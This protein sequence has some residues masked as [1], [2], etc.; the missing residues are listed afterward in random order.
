MRA[1]HYRVRPQDADVP[2]DLQELIEKCYR[3]G[4]Y[5]GT[6]NY[7]AD[8][9]PPLQGADQK[10]AGARLVELG[11]RSKRAPTKK[12]KPKTR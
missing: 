10:W 3:N 11:L 9:D 4:G 1:T 8:P 12:R 7:A 6:L 5:E 2:L